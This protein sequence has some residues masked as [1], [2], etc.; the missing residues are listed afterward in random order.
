MERWVNEISA[1]LATGNVSAKCLLNMVSFLFF[2]HAFTRKNTNMFFFLRQI[3]DFV[4]FSS[5]VKLEYLHW[6]WWKKHIWKKIF[7]TEG[8]NNSLSQIRNDHIWFIFLF[9]AVNYYKGFTK[10]IKRRKRYGFIEQNFTR[11][12]GRPNKQ[13]VT[14]KKKNITFNNHQ[15]HEMLV[16]HRATSTWQFCW[17]ATSVLYTVQWHFAWFQSS[18]SNN[19][20]MM[21]K[22]A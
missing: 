22:K 2:L 3:S 5:E 6:E 11:E 15:Q 19:K 18:T 9:S 16:Q 7:C 10:S 12:E 14:R 17:H 20:I 8:E 1:H 21:E 4:F 13:F